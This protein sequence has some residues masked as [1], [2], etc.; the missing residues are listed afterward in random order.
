MPDANDQEQSSLHVLFLTKYP[1]EG[2]SSR[3]RVYQY[4]EELRDQGIHSKVKPF[5]SSPGYRAVFQANS[6]L[7][8]GLAVLQGLTNRVIHVLRAGQYD[9]IYMQREL[10][11]FGPPFLE[12]HLKRRGARLLFDYDDALF[13]Q[14]PSAVSPLATQLRS[15]ER[16]LEIFSLADAVVAGNQWL[17]E[18]AEERGAKAYA[19]EVAEDTHRISSRPPHHEADAVTLGWLGS[20]STE[21]YLHQ[22]T[23]VLQKFFRSFPNARLVVVGGGR[24]RPE[25][26]PV[27]H[28]PWSYDTEVSQL[29]RFDIGLMPLPMEDWSRGKCGGKARTYMAAGV[30]A[31]VQDI[32]YN[33]ELIRH[34]ET[35]FLMPDDEEDWL[36]T[37]TLL[38]T[39]P[40]LRQSVGERA[41]AEV[42]TRFNL[43]RIA[44]QLADILRA[45]ARAG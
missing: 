37:L 30:P 39:D 36:G 19:L 3:Y 29:H 28:V 26:M 16:V 8:R 31:V 41:R 25:G 15:T 20:I 23:P 38:A 21:K 33:Q 32:G 9:V 13:I 12:R 7:K 18:Q 43:D 24:Y 5:Y 35:G 11:P 10:L 42:E 14:K 27:E 45:E 6:A 22:L 1:A 34:G 2:A 17:K 44:G 40:K 4:I